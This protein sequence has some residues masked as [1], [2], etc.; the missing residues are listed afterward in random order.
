MISILDYCRRIGIEPA[1][2]GSVWFVLSPF[3]TEKTPS[4]ALYEKTNSYYDWAAGHGGDLVDFHRR[5]KDLSRQDAWIDL[6]NEGYDHYTPP[7][8]LE[9]QRKVTQAEKSFIINDIREISDPR[10]LDYAQTRGISA[11]VLRSNC[12]EVYYTIKEFNFNAIGFK[13]DSGGYEIRNAKVKLSFNKKDITTIEPVPTK[14]RPSTDQVPYTN[15]HKERTNVAQVPPAAEKQVGSQIHTNDQ[16]VNINN[17]GQTPVINNNLHIFEGF[18]DYL[19][20]I[21]LLNQHFGPYVRIVLPVTTCII[22][23]SVNMIDRI[24]TDYIKGFHK[25][26]TWFDNDQAGDKATSVIRSAYPMAI[27]MREK[28]ISH[29]DLNEWYMN[30]PMRKEIT[31]RRFI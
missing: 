11:P 23:N 9:R 25:V 28:Y 14:Y 19:T 3:V 8:R 6:I 4:C 22:L 21:E 17:S 5:L 15:V 2:K 29:S 20:Y 27:D 26:Y 7:I 13:N 1:R 12:K 24:G 30:R 16:K 18:F 31:V 10:L